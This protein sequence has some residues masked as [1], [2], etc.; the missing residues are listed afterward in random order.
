[1][2]MTYG[3]VNRIYMQVLETAKDW[4]THFELGLLQQHMASW[5]QEGNVYVFCFYCSC[6]LRA[7]V[8]TENPLHNQTRI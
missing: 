8:M 7:F 5:P 2:Q 3:V 1:M 4:N 6:M